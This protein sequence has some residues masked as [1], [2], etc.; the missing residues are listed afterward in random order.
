MTRRSISALAVA[1][2]M[3]LT[4]CG[5]GGGSS[6]LSED[7]FLDEVN[8]LCAD[9]DADLDDIDTPSSLDDIEDYAADTSEIFDGLQE[10][11]AEIEAPDDLA[12]D[13]AEMQ[14]SIEEIQSLLADLEEAG[15]DGDND[16][17]ND[18]D[19]DLSGVTADLYELADDL[20]LDECVLDD[21]PAE[22]ETTE[23]P[24]TDATTVPPTAPAVVTLPPTVPQTAPPATA[25]PVTAPPA[26]APPVTETVPEST[27]ALFEVVDLTTVFND[28]FDFVMVDTGMSTALPFIEA[29]AAVP[30]LNIG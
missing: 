15:T 2:I 10:S 21:T 24:E 8:D 25:P 13:F 18:I 14:D 26:T 23:P 29:V 22:P 1:A 20:G 3:G 30:I 28:P 9:A 7:D 17:V 27:G 19:D 5:G 12:D 4:A 16:A 11:L 6:A